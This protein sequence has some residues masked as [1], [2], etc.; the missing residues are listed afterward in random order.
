MD[1]ALEAYHEMTIVRDS[2]M[3][4]R[5]EYGYTPYISGSLF[6]KIDSEKTDG[7]NTENIG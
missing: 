1:D 7:K 2:P 3:K 4:P 5:H 6:S